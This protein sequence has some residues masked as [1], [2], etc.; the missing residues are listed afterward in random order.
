M[1]H[2]WSIELGSAGLAQ[3][4]ETWESDAWPRIL[5]DDECERAARFRM[6]GDGLRFIRR[7]AALRLI[8]ARYTGTEPD[9]LQ[10]VYGAS[11]KPALASPAGRAPLHFNL[12]DS[13]DLALI[14][15]TRA[16]PVGID[17]ERLRPIPEADQIAES[18]FSARERAEL[19]QLPA[20]ARQVAFF[21]LWTRKEAVLKAEGHGLSEPLDRVE[22]LLD[23]STPA[24]IRSIGGDHAAAAR[25]WVAEIDPAPGYIG[26]VA[27]QRHDLHMRRFRFRPQF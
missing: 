6:L 5:S 23:A 2:L 3:E 21:R 27:V 17:I 26:A 7:R 4:A 10:F 19:A 13:E 15:V 25:W 1:L 9:A 22:V 8:L 24:C 18:F 11:G 16:A 12:T 14:A 20:V